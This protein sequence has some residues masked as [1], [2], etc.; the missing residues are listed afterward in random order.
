MVVA[1]YGKARIFKA[2]SAY[3]RVVMWQS[4]AGKMITQVQPGP[5]LPGNPGKS[6]KFNKVKIEGPAKCPKN[7]LA[8]IIKG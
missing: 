5:V 2:L 1:F 6:G 8:S 7:G 4:G 3:N